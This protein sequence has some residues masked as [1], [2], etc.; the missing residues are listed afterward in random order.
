[1]LSASVMPLESF[2]SFF[3]EKKAAIAPPVPEKSPARCHLF[4]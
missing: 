4:L 1:M 3:F 2:V